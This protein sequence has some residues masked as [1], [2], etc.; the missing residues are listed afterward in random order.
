MAN[1]EKIDKFDIREASTV[2]IPN[3]Q[4]YF[5]NIFS[6]E[7]LR[8]ITLYDLAVAF[9]D[10]LLLKSDINKYLDKEIVYVTN[11]SALPTTGD[12]AKR[13]VTQ[14]SIT[15]GGIVYPASHSYVWDGVKYADI[16][17]GDLILGETSTTA[18]RGDRGKVAYD[19]VNGVSVSSLAG[20]DSIKQDVRI[21]ITTP[22]LY[23]GNYV[24]SAECGIISGSSQLQYYQIIYCINGSSFIRVWASVVWTIWQPFDK[25]SNITATSLGLAPF[26]NLTPATLPVSTAQSVINTSLSTSLGSKLE[27]V[28]L[29]YLAQ[30]SA[31]ANYRLVMA[32]T[33]VL[34]LPGTTDAIISVDCFW[35]QLTGL[36][37]QLGYQV[38]YTTGGIYYRYTTNGSYSGVSF[39]KL[40]STTSPSIKTMTITKDEQNPDTYIYTYTILSSDSIY[41]ASVLRSSWIDNTGAQKSTD[42]VIKYIFTNGIITGITFDIGYELTGNNIF[43]FEKI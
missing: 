11:Y 43:T 1:L 21:K 30:L 23:S 29:Q 24:I 15:I 40:G 31:L 32:S 19:F 26:V 39:V 3:L 28:P 22:F 37:E 25:S 5:A 34:L 8:K 20:L 41:G 12:V 6:A 36:G 18:Y 4:A 16:T 42:S 17:A 9:G 10:V 7:D 2:N 27:I 33:S 38:A 35:G 13:Y 14:N